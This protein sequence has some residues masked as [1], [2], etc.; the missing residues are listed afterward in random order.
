MLCFGSRISGDDEDV[1]RSEMKV[2]MMIKKNVTREKKINR[3]ENI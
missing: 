3:R 2:S 1:D